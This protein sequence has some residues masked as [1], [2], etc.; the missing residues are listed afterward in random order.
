[1]RPARAYSINYLVFYATLGCIVRAI[2]KNPS[3]QV[4]RVVNPWQYED[5]ACYDLILA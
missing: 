3:I 5:K 4:G 2:M 1:M